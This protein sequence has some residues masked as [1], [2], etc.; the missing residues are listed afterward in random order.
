MQ[1]LHIAVALKFQYHHKDLARDA[2]IYF[3]LKSAVCSS[4]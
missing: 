1:H 3:A 4:D 2:A